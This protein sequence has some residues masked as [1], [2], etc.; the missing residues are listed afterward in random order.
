MRIICFETA[1]IH[2]YLSI[3]KEVSFLILLP[4][5]SEGEG[6]LH[7]D[8]GRPV[9]FLILRAFAM[10]LFYACIFTFLLRTALTGPGCA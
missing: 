6:G 3:T 7:E 5:I 9:Y 2:V 10:S 1:I 4:I 8:L